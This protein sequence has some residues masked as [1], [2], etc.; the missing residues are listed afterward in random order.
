MM[1]LNAFAAT[2]PPHKKKVLVIGAH[3]DDP[4]TGCGG[5][6]VWLKEAGCEVVAVYMTKGEG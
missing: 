5:T 6:M 4:E 2:E 3:P 1:G